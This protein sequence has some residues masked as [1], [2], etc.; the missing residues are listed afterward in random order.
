MCNGKVSEC[1]MV[2]AAAPGPD[3]ALSTLNAFPVINSLALT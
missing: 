1:G 2:T 3:V